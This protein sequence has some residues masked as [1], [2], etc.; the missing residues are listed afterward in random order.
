MAQW[1]E[2]LAFLPEDPGSVPRTHNIWLPTA[3]APSSDFCRYRMHTDIQ[4]HPHT[5]R[6]NLV[7]NNNQKP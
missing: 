6:I 1:L 2:A 7:F 3:P 5:Y 4:T